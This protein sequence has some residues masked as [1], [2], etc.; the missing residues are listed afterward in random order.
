MAWVYLI[1]AGLF[2][3]GGVIGMNKVAQKKSIANFSFLFGS[4]IFSFT[5]LAFAMKTLPMGVSYAVWTG[6]GTVGGTLIGMFVYNE[7]KDWKR[8]L[9]ISFIIIAVVGLKVTQ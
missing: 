7:S 6:I 9:F 4:F 3:V 5:L 1:F 8:I 2:E